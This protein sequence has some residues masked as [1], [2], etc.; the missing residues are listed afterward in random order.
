MWICFTTRLF[1]LQPQIAKRHRNHAR[2]DILG[3]PSGNA[4]ARPNKSRTIATGSPGRCSTEIDIHVEAPAVEYKELSSEERAESSEAIRERVLRARKLQQERFAGKPRCRANAQ[5]T[6][7]LLRTHCKLD[8]EGRELL[9]RA[10]EELHLSARAYD[11]ILKVAR[12]I[13]DL[14]ESK[15]IRPPQVLEAINTG[16]STAIFGID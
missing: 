15:D 10:M 16:R 2:A 3:I 7:G 9:R 13:A 4:A 6:H 12:T 1:G 8:A 5:M 11:R 14:A